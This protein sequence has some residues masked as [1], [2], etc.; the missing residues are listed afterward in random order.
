MLIQVLFLSGCGKSS[1][2][3]EVLQDIQ[4]RAQER[5]LHQAQVQFQHHH[6]SQAITHLQHFFA[7]HS[8]SPLE[9]KARWLLARAYKNK[10]DLDAAL[11]Q[12][13]MIAQSLP[14]GKERL[15]TL[16][17][18]SGLGQRLQGRVSGAGHIYAVRVPLHR[19]SAGKDIESSLK[20]LARK[21]VTTVLL[22]FACPSQAR[23]NGNVKG[24][25]REVRGVNLTSFQR[26]PSH[27][28]QIHGQG[29][30]ALVGINLRCLGNWGASR[31]ISWYDRSYNPVSKTVQIS[32]YFDLYNPRYQEF[33][34]RFL[35]KLANSPVDGIVFQAESPVGVYDG[36]TPYSLQSFAQA[37]Q[38]RVSP[39]ALFKNGQ[40]SHR[41]KVTNPG[42]Q[43]GISSHPQAPEFWRWAGWKTRQRLAVLQHLMEQVH[44]R[45]PE[46]KFGLEVHSESIENPLRGLVQFSED[47]LEAHRMGF[48]FFIV[49]PHSDHDDQLNQ[50]LRDSKRILD[51]TRVL[52]DRMVM[53]TNDSSK[54]WVT[55]PSQA[56]VLPAHEALWGR[57]NFLRGVGRLYDLP[58][59][60]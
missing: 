24:T 21:G 41:P 4:L 31:K 13:K 18:I 15:E 3:Q 58:A 60:P 32:Q 43:N 38:V 14:P 56:T 51:Q 53:V 28:A 10:G 22:D 16:Q 45:K 25:V 55:V 23:E 40:N 47:F 46:L 54:I 27:L 11:E 17:Q 42:N 6:Y 59:L 44:Q 8:P 39:Q 19:F 26:L 29:L 5:L 48:A 35:I 12:Y 52:V 34:G 9:G 30:E 2:R 49:T 1:Y 36:L 33:L 20:Q 57:K 7:I 37:F 50:G